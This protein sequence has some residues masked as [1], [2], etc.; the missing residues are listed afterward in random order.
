MIAEPDSVV[1]DRAGPDLRSLSEAVSLLA[2]V[3]D[4]GALL[5]ALIGLLRRWTDCEAVG[6]RLR[7][8]EDY[9]YYTTLG[10]AEAFVVTENSL[11]ALDQ[12]GKPIRDPAGQVVLE[13]LCGAVIAGHSDPSQPFFTAR[14]TFFT[15]S[16]TRL[17]AMACPL[18]LEGRTR[19]RCNA[20]GY[21]TV[22]LT[23]LRAGGKTFGLL[24]IN[25]RRPDRLDR[26]G[27]ENLERLA[28]GVA[29][30]LSRHEMEAALAAAEAR[31]RAMF[32]TNIAVKLLIDPADGRIVDANPAA[33]AYYGYSQE[34]MRTL[35]I[36]DIN[37]MSPEQ[38]REEMGR[39]KNEGR[40][41]FRFTH[42]LAGG[43]LREVEVYSGP[44][45]YSG[46]TLLFSI[47]HDV[48]DRVRAEQARERVE[49]MLRHDL[50]SPLS[51]IVGLSSRLVRCD[52]PPSAR[53]KAEVIRETA[54][55]L[56]G[57]VE[58][59]LD[60]CKIEQGRYVLSPGPVHLASL[61]RRLAR[62][63]QPLAASRQVALVLYGD[64]LEEDGGGENGPV[65]AG[66]ADL[67]GTMFANLVTNA[68]E[69]APTGST[70]TVS[71]AQ[72]GVTALAAV[73][74]HGAIP[75]DIRSQF[76]MKYVTSGK[77]GGTGLGAYIARVI[78]RLHG[79]D[80]DWVSSEVAGTRL[81]VRLPLFD[82]RQPA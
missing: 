76:F 70:V 31:Y 6:V 72:N 49:Q 52:L 50:R 26:A 54:E 77:E 44:V 28:D 19:N 75:E 42:R 69:A 22:V 8:G 27:V 62:E 29:M 68:L 67:L 33:C 14:G 41:F 32:F 36:W 73:H 79:G 5:R 48:T 51:G 66:E 71:L 39:A 61:L 58:R 7:Q 24:Q 9:P 16:T 38:V 4:S 18:G 82:R 63:S 20:A 57:L 25:D 47:I 81:T 12:A 21:E 64:G 1:A 23:P 59:T 43:E 56:Y 15:G 17:M 40:G 78:A 37:T 11:C 30:L 13:C 65:A 80:I 10:F 53:E 3:P 55:R 45:E 60:L 2:A 35:S 74:N 34:T 46:R